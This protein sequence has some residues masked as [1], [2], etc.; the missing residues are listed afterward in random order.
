M[1][2]RQRRHRLKQRR[3]VEKERQS[4]RTRTQMAASCT[5]APNPVPTHRVKSSEFFS[6]FCWL[7]PDQIKTSLTGYGCFKHSIGSSP[8][9]YQEP[10]SG[11]L[12]GLV[13]PPRDGG[14]LIL[15]GGRVGEQV[16]GG[17]RPGGSKLQWKQQ[18]M[19]QCLQAKGCHV[20][21]R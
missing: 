19:L 9:Y 5:F 7:H 20:K 16:R 4:K 12:P 15:G 13:K 3:S 17:C 6:S 21:R 18:G 10:R 14:S 11:A 2:D 8:R 1:S